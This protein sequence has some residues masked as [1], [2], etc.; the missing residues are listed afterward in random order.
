MIKINYLKAIKME[1]INVLLFILVILKVH[2]HVH[3]YY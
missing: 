1:V 2:I 3:D